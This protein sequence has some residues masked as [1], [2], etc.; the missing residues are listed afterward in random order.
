MSESGS[1]CPGQQP[2]DTVLRTRPSSLILRNPRGASEPASRGKDE[3]QL[4]T[5]CSQRRR[6][7]SGT[8]CP[9]GAR[10]PEKGRGYVR[11]T[12]KGCGYKWRGWGYRRRGRAW[13]FWE[14]TFSEDDSVP[15][16]RAVLLPLL[17]MSS[18]E[19]MGPHVRA[20]Q[21]SWVRPTG[22]MFKWSDFS[23]PITK[24][25]TIFP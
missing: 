5:V 4:G 19:F 6:R 15:V 24:L 16:W 1:P 17:P 10:L 3:E 18:H 11:T 7:Q 22:P 9:E 8:Q 2:Q 21:S 13:A 20:T 23:L 25:S 12:A 14:I